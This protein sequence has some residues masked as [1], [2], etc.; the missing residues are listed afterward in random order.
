INGNLTETESII[1]ARI[2]IEYQPE[3]IFEIGT[4]NGRTT[5]N[6]AMNTNEN[7][8]I[9]TLDLPLQKRAETK[10][11]T[12]KHERGYINKKNKPLVFLNYQDIKRKIQPLYG[13]SATF[14]ITPFEESIDM[15][16]IDGSHT[17]EYVL[18]DTQLALKLL[19]PSGGIIL[20]HDYNSATYTG[21][22]RAL[23]KLRSEIESLKNIKNIMGTSLAFADTRNL[24]K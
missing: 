20:W 24:Q 13:D 10:Y 6:I 17:Y 11:R 18:N 12:S 3:R 16:F 9:F 22:N 2:L 4:F 14:D 5:M 21:V 8:K 19:R 15:I 1:I 23:I 7:A